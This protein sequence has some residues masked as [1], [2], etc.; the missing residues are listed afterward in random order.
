MGFEY[1]PKT[2]GKTS[3]SQSGGAKCGALGAEN[4]QTDLDLHVIIRRWPD[5]PEA[6]KAGIL[7]M[8][9]ANDD[10]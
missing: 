3:D 5:L 2:T 7:A 4:A 9:N 8:V 6:T 10:A 1:V